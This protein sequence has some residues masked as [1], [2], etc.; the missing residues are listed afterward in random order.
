M[1]RLKALREEQGLSQAALARKVK[2]PLSREYIARLEMGRHDPSLSTV[3]RIAKALK[4]KIS[5]LLE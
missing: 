2:P 4:V 3:A 5:E 1:T